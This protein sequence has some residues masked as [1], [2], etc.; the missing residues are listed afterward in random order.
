MLLL[1]N[2]LWISIDL[3]GV[4]IKGGEH[5]KLLESGRLITTGPLDRESIPKVAFDLVCVVRRSSSEPSDAD[6]VFSLARNFTLF[7]TDVDDNVPRLQKENQYHYHIWLNGLGLK[8]VVNRPTTTAII[9]YLYFKTR[10]RTVCRT[11][12]IRNQH[13]SLSMK[14]RDKKIDIT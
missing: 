6:L 14:T 13:W 10:V 12:N 8:E 9:I 11:S 4:D 1:V 5:V 3:F 7:V 2:F